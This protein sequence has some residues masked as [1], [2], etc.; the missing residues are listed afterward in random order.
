M[1]RFILP[2]L[3]LAMAVVLFLS[4]TQ[5]NFSQTK[6]L[7]ADKQS[8]EEALQ[9]SREL[10]TLRD[11]LLTQYNSISQEDLARLNELLPPQIDSGSLIVILEDRA[12][13]RGLLL[14]KI[15]VSEKKLT[16]DPFAVIGAAL[17]PFRV[18]GLS[19]SVSGSYGSFLEFLADLEKSLRIIDVEQI[20]F[21]G[22]A[23]EVIE[24][25]LSAK[26]Y[27]ANPSSE[28]A[29]A[30]SEGEGQEEKSQD[31]KEILAMLAKLKSVKIDADFF[32]NEAFKGLVKFA[33]GLVMPKEYGRINPF[34]PLEGTK[35]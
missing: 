16:A 22:G 33:P 14:K 6:V 4:Q 2:I 1:T 20:V 27:A 30:F 8:F 35:K 13:N 10:Q 21:S 18:L 25:Q 5:P 17:P 7:K 34:A 29:A 28:T 3:F 11:E 26:T 32:Q 15:D 31:A 23:S 19:L 24:F 12:K 9:Y